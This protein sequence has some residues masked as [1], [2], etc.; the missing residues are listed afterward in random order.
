MRYPS[1][2]IRLPFL[3]LALALTVLPQGCGTP[4]APEEPKPPAPVEVTRVSTGQQLH[5]W[6]E[7]VGSTQPLPD[8][9]ARVT[10]PIE[11]QVLAVLGDGGSGPRLREGQP[12][13]KGDVIVQLDDRVLRA[14]LARLE[15]TA[16]KLNDQVAQADVAV[17]QAQ[18]E[19]NRLRK[20]R[21]QRVTV[22]ESEQQKA[23]LALKDARL[24]RK[25]VE[26][27]RKVSEAEID[28]LKV[29]Q[30]LYALRAPLDG[31]LGRLEVKQGQTLPA[32]TF[33]AEIMDLSGHI[34]VLCYVPPARIERIHVGQ[35]AHITTGEAATAKLPEGQVVFKD[36]QANP[37]TGNYAV[38]VRFGNQAMK[39]LANAVV[40][41]RVLTRTVKDAMTIPEEAV[42]EDQEPPTV[43]VVRDIKEKMNEESKKT[44]LI[45]EAFKV[46]VKLG[47]RDRVTRQVQIVALL[48][49]G[50]KEPADAA[51]ARAEVQDQW[52]VVKGGY[53]LEDKDKV[54]V[55]K[56][57]EEKK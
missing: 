55:E 1:K 17:E 22:A 9:V 2:P 28:A 21:D 30:G 13:K 16:R 7:L 34:D 53:G 38:K 26:T 31:K 54:K 42:M 15:A 46:P 8:K 10:A 43:V 37:D 56:P 29:Q 19:V 25:A 4:A 47:L 23:D 44:E 52:Y 20:L 57:K 51:K 36:D 48:G 11:G 33:V 3:L 32:G 35:P 39:L 50:N 45:G 27:D 24:K 12:V 14:N 5:E 41:V 49:E 40:R 18:I 6:T